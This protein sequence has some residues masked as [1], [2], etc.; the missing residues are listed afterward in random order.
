MGRCKI[1]D[2]G[3][4]AGGEGMGKVDIVGSLFSRAMREVTIVVVVVVKICRVL[5]GG[6]GA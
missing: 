2:P 4:A 6:L 3:V 1:I 5:G